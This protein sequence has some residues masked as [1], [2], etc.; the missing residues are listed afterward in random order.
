[1]ID[2]HRHIIFIPELL[3]GGLLRRSKQIVSTN[4][5]SRFERPF[6]QALELHAVNLKDS[7]PF[8]VI[9]PW[10]VLSSEDI[11]QGCRTPFPKLRGH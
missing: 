9:T 11:N 6:V 5:R 7:I 1:M 2:T 3:F 4:D 10:A 8:D